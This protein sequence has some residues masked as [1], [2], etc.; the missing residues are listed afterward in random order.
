MRNEGKSEVQPIRTVCFF[1][2]RAKR[3][4]EKRRE[5]LNTLDYYLSDDLSNWVIVLNHK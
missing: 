1:P 2:E 3:E 4:A 5:E